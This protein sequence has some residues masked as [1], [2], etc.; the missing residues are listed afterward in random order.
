MSTKLISGD[1]ALS[2]F[3]KWLQ[4]RSF[5]RIDI[6]VDSH[7][8][9]ACLRLLKDQLGWEAM[10]IVIPAGE[11]S[12]NLEG[13][14]KVWMA[15]LA[16]ASDRNS[17]LINLGG[18]MITD[19]GGMAA[20]TFKRGI[21]FVQIP[22]SLLGQVD[23]AIGHKTGIDVG[24]VKNSVGTFSAPEELV[25][26]PVFLETL[27]HEEY[28]SGM[29]EVF[30][31]SLVQDKE[32]WFKLNDYRLGMACSSEIIQQAADVKVRIVEEDPR[33]QG[34]RKLLNFG[35][36]LGH[37]VESEALAQGATIR[38]G[39]AVAAGMMMEAWISHQK[40][41]LALEEWEQIRNR[42]VKVYPQ[43]PDTILN[44][45]RCVAFLKND[46]KNLGDSIRMVLLNHIGEGVIDQVV[47]NELSRKALDA[48][49]DF[50]MK[51]TD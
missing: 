22:T 36:S 51:T 1:H 13:L 37:A 7:T 16:G 29:A 20:S 33:E 47:S 14:H 27:P 48:Y 17:L 8:E 31:H 49:P 35:H 9:Q 23:A 15:L 40:G 18:G 2:E 46:K 38:H 50:Y 44:G 26:D 3:A 41:M 21:P 39:E 30:K 12:K 25:I 19:L 45:D 43:L 34:Q 5:S 24:G 28:R 32:L 10:P 6:L 42:L 4:S 11:A